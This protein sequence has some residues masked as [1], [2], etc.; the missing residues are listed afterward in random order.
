L[1]NLSIERRD[2]MPI[3]YDKDEERR[4]ERDYDEEIKDE[5][6]RVIPPARVSWGAIFAGTA[7]A[8]AVGFT[9]SL[10]GGAIGLQAMDFGQGADPLSGFGVG[11]GLWL[12]FQIVV[13]LFVGGWVAGRLASK[14]KGIDGI[15]N[16]TVVWAVAILLGLFGITTLAGNVIGGAATAVSQGVS[17]EPGAVEGAVEEA[18]AEAEAAAQQAQ[19]QPGQAAAAADT[20]ASV[21]WWTLLGIVLGLISAA[22]GGLVGSPKPEVWRERH[23]RRRRIRVGGRRSP[24]TPA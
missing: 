3:E 23:E 22:L 20:A 14:P 18:T 1:A 21:M 12:A 24:P 4:A 9:L 5:D 6:E 7:M 15:L 11:A 13:A 10:L 2:I 19:A 16:G 8:L 17:L